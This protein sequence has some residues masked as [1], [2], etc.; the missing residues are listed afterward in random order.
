MLD[1]PVL[2]GIAERLGC[3]LGQ[4]CIGWA[5]RKGVAVATKTEKES[6]MVENLESIQVAP[7]LTDEDIKK[8]DALNMDLKKYWN[9]YA[10]A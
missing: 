5:L 10:I 3:S 8:I 1:D 2:K 6:R 7:K 4:A 9:P